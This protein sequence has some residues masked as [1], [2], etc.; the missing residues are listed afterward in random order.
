MSIQK[1]VCALLLALAGASGLQAALPTETKK[2]LDAHAT[3][4]TAILNTCKEHTDARMGFNVSQQKWLPGYYIKYGIERVSNAQ[5]LKHDIAALNLSLLSV[6]EK[7]IYQL[8]STNGTPSNDNCLVI[9]KAVE[10][11]DNNNQK[12]TREHAKQLCT[13]AM[14]ANHYDLHARNYLLKQDGTICIID[15]D[16]HAMPSPEE[17]ERLRQDWIK[18]G[19]R[20]RHPDG[21]VA[22]DPE[23]INHPLT[24][25]ELPL[26]SKHCNYDQQAYRYVQEE[27]QKQEQLRLRPNPTKKILQVGA[28]LAAAYGIY[29]A[30]SAL[31]NSRWV[32][33]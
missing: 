29:K 28:A 27:V 17:I 6:P 16:N 15:T 21:G 18:N 19:T 25:L 31:L 30:V 2:I 33:A 11:A 22:M 3:D 23:I 4:L 13:L 26:Y 1:L 7:Y 12:L 24:K 20:I 14:R 10:H 8:P 5:K 9:V 32:K